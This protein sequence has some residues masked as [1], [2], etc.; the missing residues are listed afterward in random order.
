VE[1]KAKNLSVGAFFLGGHRAIALF[2]WKN[3]DSDYL[4]QGNLFDPPP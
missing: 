4:V 3:A 2:L 1:T